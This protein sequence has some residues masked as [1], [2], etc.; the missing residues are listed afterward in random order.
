M[1]HPDPTTDF[2]SPIAGRIE[3]REPC[4]WCPDRPMIPR[5]QMDEHC[6]RLH[7][8]V[9]VLAAPAVVPSAGRAALRDRIAE[10]L[11]DHLART[12]DIRLTKSG[13]YAFVP[14]VTDPERMRI[15]DAVLA[16][17]PEPTTRA[18]ASW[19]ADFAEDVAEK[20][21]SHHEFERSNGALDV[22]AELRRL[23]GEPQPTHSETRR[24]TCEHP[25]DEHSIYGCVDGCACEW[26]PKRTPVRHAP[27]KVILCPDC[28]AKGYAICMPDVPAAGAGQDGAQ[29][30]DRIVAYRSALPGAWSL[31][32]TRHLDELGDGTPL[33]A[34]DLPDGGLC[35]Q[36]GVDVLIEQEPRS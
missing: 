7:P 32:C 13:E 30:G 2:T 6:A 27:G 28:C 12:A 29:E 19:A 8:E 10:A 16:V 18:A 25:A 1:T 35:A 33:T 20:L 22:A 4:P 24:C 15:V 31:Y 3:V 9:Q 21:R 23:A 5:S 36:C 14:E 11:H 17:L 34:D 26:M